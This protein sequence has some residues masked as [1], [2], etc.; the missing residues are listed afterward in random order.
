MPLFSNFPLLQCQD[1]NYIRFCEM[2][3]EIMSS[4]LSI[5]TY[6]KFETFSN[7]KDR[8]REKMPLCLVDGYL[9]VHVGPTLGTFLCSSKAIPPVLPLNYT[10]AASSRWEWPVGQFESQI[11]SLPS[12]IR[13][14]L[15]VT[16]SLK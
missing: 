11:I 3:D 6:L 4:G 7:E 16:P 10:V 15:M 12:N 13:M 9:I 1:V 5:D 2:S 8:L 14:R